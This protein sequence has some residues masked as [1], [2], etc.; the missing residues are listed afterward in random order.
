MRRNKTSAVFS[1]QQYTEAY[2]DGMAN[3]YWT[4][5]RNR[6]VESKIRQTMNTN[7]TILDIGTGRGTTVQWLIRHNLDC[8]GCEIGTPKIDPDVK[9][10]IFTATNAFNLPQK[11]RAHIST[12][13]ILDVLEHLKDPGSMLTQC[14]L[15]FP[16]LKTL[17]ITVPACSSLWSNYDEY[18]GH[19]RRYDRTGLQNLIVNHG[20]RLIECG[21]FFHTLYIP[22][23]LLMQIFR[24]RSTI[25][26]PPRHT[27]LH[28]WLASI[29]YWETKIL[30]Q[31]WLG[32]SLIAVASPLGKH[33]NNHGIR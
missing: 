1:E 7:G 24:Q 17:I 8:Y 11:F 25:L 23:R 20:F 6:L 18:Y 31:T 10:K 2:P 27:R 32:T 12:I 4:I 30:P 9:D 22:A 5:N 13:L 28:S 16:R 26:P 21:Y 29:F 14:R 15:K 33:L 19:Y 3:H